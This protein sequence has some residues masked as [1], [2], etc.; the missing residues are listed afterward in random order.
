MGFLGLLRTA[1][2]IALTLSP[3]AALAE[4]A[5]AEAE[6]AL[7]A[8]VLRVIGGYVTWPPGPAPRAEQPFLI[9]ILGKSP[10]ANLLEEA[11]R[12]RAVRGR[13][14]RIA[15]HTEASALT[16]C[17]LVFLCAS[18]TARL[19]RWLPLFRNRPVFL[20]GDTP[21][22]AAQG[23]MLNL[24]LRDGTLTLE[25]NLKAARAAGFEISPSFLELTKDKLR[26]VTPA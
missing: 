5:P 8:R 1:A 24:L 4:A 22:F 15:Y 17:D 9:G 16:A 25:V 20:M 26:I 23:I 13:P 19:P 6:V 7:K 11:C 12:G 21:G 18:E 2:V 10:F 3:R 14:I